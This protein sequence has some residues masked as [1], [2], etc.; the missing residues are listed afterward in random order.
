[1]PLRKAERVG[2]HF[3]NPVPTQIGGFSTLLKM[4]P[5][6]LTHRAARTPAAPLG[7]FQTDSSVYQ[8]TPATGLRI[9]W[10]GHSSSLVEIDGVKILIDPVWDERAAP[11]QWFG[12]KRFF[13]P[14]IALEDLPPLDAIV[15]SHDH[16]D[17]LGA[18]TI[19]RL[20]NMDSMQ[21]TRWITSLGVGAIL[22]GLG[23]APQRC[24]ELDWTEQ[25]QLGPLTI[26]ALPTRHFSGR[27][28]FNRFETLWS[29]F[30][31]IGPNHRVY[32]G[33]DSG[34][35]SGFGEIGRTYGPFD[36]TMLEIGAF[37]PLW[38]N[39]HMGP[40]GAVRSFG[41]LGGQGL[42]MPIHW[43][44]FNLAFHPWQQPIETVSAVQGLKLWSPAPGVPTEIVP[45]EQVRSDWWNVLS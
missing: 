17:H 11:Y 21:N 18:H 39:I 1:M 34:E 22:A 33:S 23:V 19:R 28:L 15:I 36:L 37:D 2:Q 44:L 24:T 38:A 30:A 12:P 29:A 45:D 8:T 9:T 43:G 35:W 27:S 7:P 6:A 10:F 42:L 5:R 25:A 16:Y 32:Y 41:E 3:V 14:T 40:E 31:L 4:L 26:T 13:A 20:A